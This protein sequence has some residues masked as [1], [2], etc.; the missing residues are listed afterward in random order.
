[1]ARGGA[2]RRLFSG[3][4]RLLAAGAA[5]L[6]ASRGFSIPRRALADGAERA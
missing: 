6:A 4:G 2:W 3:R 1:M 5:P